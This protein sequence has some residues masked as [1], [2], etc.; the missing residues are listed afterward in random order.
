[1]LYESALTLELSELKAAMSLVRTHTFLPSL[2]YA[3]RKVEYWLSDQS[4]L[5][6]ADYTQDGQGWCHKIILKK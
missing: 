3:F 1:M 2:R 4:Q 6:L 5:G